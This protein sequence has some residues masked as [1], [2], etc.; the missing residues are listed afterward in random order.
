M[1]KK[2]QSALEYLMTY[3]WA[4]IV[5]AIVIGI[6][7]Y[8]TST[9]TGGTVCQSQSQE[10]VVK[11]YSITTGTGGVNLSLTNKT[12]GTISGVSAVSSGSFPGS[13]TNTL[14]GSFTVGTNFAIKNN[15]PTAAGAYSNGIVTVTFNV[16]GGVPHTAKIVCSGTV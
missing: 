10:L 15:G 7:I 6:L 8:V 9:S 12:S 2:G 13:D 11:D 16:A 1:N 3:G 5:I 14:A 4:L